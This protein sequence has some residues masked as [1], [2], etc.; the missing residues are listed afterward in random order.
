MAKYDEEQQMAIDHLKVVAGRRH[1][2]K[3][4]IAEEVRKLEERAYA[5][6]EQEM[7][8][9]VTNAV[10]KGVATRQVGIAWGTKDF[11]TAKKLVE[12]YY[13]PG[14]TLTDTADA[15]ADPTVAITGTPE[16]PLLTLTNWRA[17]ATTQTKCMDGSNTPV[18]N[19]TEE[20]LRLSQSGRWYMID[21]RDGVHMVTQRELA[22]P[23]SELQQTVT[24]H[25]NALQEEE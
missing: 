9:A 2:I 20:P 8:H 12:T 15:T 13:Q 22:N 1:T 21:K 24:E 11:G 19:L 23:R 16:A 25:V 3:E 6:W 4:H 17:H 18:L 5:E 7:A 14:D 10:S